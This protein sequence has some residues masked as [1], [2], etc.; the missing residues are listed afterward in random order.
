MEYRWAIPGEIATGSLP[1]SDL[2]V[3]TL[4]GLGIRAVLSLHRPPPVVTE[5]LRAAG[6]QHML[7]ELEDYG[8]PSVEQ[9]HQIRMILESWRE[10]DR[11]VYVHCYAGVGRCRTVAAAFLAMKLGS[12][13]EALE[14]VGQPE[15]RRQVEFVRA[16][17]EISAAADTT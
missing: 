15:T 12:A 16:Y 1:R 9:M 3:R 6:V 14:M 8:V 10:A 5:A 2:D 4:R 17:A 11:P 13:D 7:S